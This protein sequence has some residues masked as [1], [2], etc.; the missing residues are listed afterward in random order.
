[1]PEGPDVVALATLDRSA[2]LD[3]SAAE[4]A[5]GALMAAEPKDIP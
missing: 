4:K 5:H 2:A 1:M 3:L